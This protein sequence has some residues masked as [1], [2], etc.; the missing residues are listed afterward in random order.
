MMAMV[1]VHLDGAQ[2]Y[3][4]TH[5]MALLT[6]SGAERVCKVGMPSEIFVYMYERSFSNE[7]I[8][9]PFSH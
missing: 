1:A 9:D 5:T 3:V 7:D 4:S 8:R 6:W 2:L